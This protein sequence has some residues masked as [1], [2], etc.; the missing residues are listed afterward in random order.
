MTTGDGETV[1]VSHLSDEATELFV[2]WTSCANPDLP[3]AETFAWQG[4]SPEAWR[5]KMAEQE[6]E[7]MELEWGL[8]MGTALGMGEWAAD[9]EQLSQNR[10]NEN[11]IAL[12]RAL[13]DDQ[14]CCGWAT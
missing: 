3:L 7:A 10:H 14:V 6:S 4:I 5:E 12:I 1:D 8:L 13:A 9:H 11:T 2:Q